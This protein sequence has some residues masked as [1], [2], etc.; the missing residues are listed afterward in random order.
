MSVAG[1]REDWGGPAGSCYDRAMR[2]SLPS[3]SASI[4]ASA[5]SLALA[6]L[7][8]MGCS[9]PKA[10]PENPLVNEG[11]AV[12]DGCCCKT[13]PIT[14]VDG[15]PV[16]ERGVNRMECSTGQGTCVDD[17]QCKDAPPAP[18]RSPEPP[19]GE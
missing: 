15:A 17:V 10:K 2:I 14:S 7:L 19:P 18:T 3:I 11:S 4:S 5:S 1:A 9:G 12:P 6:A 13:H 16:Y 8:A